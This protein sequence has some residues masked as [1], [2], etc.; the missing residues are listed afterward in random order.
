MVDIHCHVLHEMDDGAKSLAD[1]I[2]LCMLGAENGIEKIVLTPHLPNINDI[3]EFIEKR[4][5]KI[6]ELQN[7]IDE[8][9]I[10]VEIYPGAEVYVNDDI[11]F[12]HNL[13]KAVI[14]SGKYFLSE[15]DFF[16][17]SMD[18]ICRYLDE[19]KKNGLIPIIAHPERYDYFQRDY[20]KINYLVAEKDVLF[21]VNAGSLAGLGT[22]E[23][24]FLAYQ[25]VKKNI[26]SFIGTD[27]H[28]VKGRA[29]DLLRLTHFFPPDIEHRSLDYMVNIAPESV[30]KNEQLPKINR[31]RLQKG[32]WL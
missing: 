28:S 5:E 31:G 18:R 14:N 11:F 27:A 9:Q 10:D 22:R 7:E 4:D 19:V 17:L 25:M 26:A 16:G 1:S 32:R 29:N 21:Q 24:F 13:K 2:Q 8:R 3:D 6:A 12:S 15:F 23:E 20:N 30:L